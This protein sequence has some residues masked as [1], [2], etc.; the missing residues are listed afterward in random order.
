M[1]IIMIRLITAVIVVVTGLLGCSHHQGIFQD[2]ETS[3]QRYSQ[4]QRQETLIFMD[5]ETMFPDPQLR[6]LAK[7]AGRGDIR[8]ID[9][10]ISQGV[11]V[12]ARGHR[13]ATP[14][15][16]A[17]KNRRGFESLLERGAD[18]NVVFD[19]GGSVL[20]WL[21]KS[22]NAT[23]LKLALQFGGDPNLKASTMNGSVIFETFG[24]DINEGIPEAMKLLIE[25]GADVNLKNEKGVTVVNMAALTNRFDVV[26]YLLEQGADPS[27]QM[28][29][30]SDLTSIIERKKTILVPSSDE[31]MWLRRAELWLK[32][33]H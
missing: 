30:G 7:A 25:N 17:M 19:D 18:P 16:W 8:T 21:A 13:N 15:F 14:L 1:S 9:R 23:L 5:L 31:A 10:L 29:S 20:H 4:K 24:L 26:I 28:T 32:K 3:E 27:L 11:N 22:K 12:N 33:H 2:M 6:A